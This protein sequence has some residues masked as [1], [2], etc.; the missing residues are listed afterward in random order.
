MAPTDIGIAYIA[1]FLD[2]QGAVFTVSAR[3]G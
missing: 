1:V 3:L 2:P